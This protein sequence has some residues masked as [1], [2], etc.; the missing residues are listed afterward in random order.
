M[1][2]QN[3]KFYLLTALAVF[4]VGLFCLSLWAFFQSFNFAFDGSTSLSHHFGEFEPPSTKELI[5][6][7][8]W[9]K[10]AN[11]VLEHSWIVLVPTLLSV[12]IAKTWQ[13]KKLAKTP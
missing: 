1:K 13:S 9:L 10:M 8:M 12:P 11:L 5:K 3:A 7:A 2:I 4:A 6:Q